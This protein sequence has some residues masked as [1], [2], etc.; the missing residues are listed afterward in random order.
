MNSQIRILRFCHH[1]REHFKNM[2]CNTSSLTLAKIVL[3]VNKQSQN[4]NVLKWVV[5]FKFGQKLWGDLFKV[6]RCCNQSRDHLRNVNC[7]DSCLIFAK[8]NISINRQP[9]SR[10]SLKSTFQIKF[11]QTLWSHCFKRLRFLSFTWPFQKCRRY[12]F[13]FDIR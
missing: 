7:S 1:S 11:E 8:I 3:S 12:Y 9:Q 5:Q 13:Q 6:S 2:G 10:N 4:R